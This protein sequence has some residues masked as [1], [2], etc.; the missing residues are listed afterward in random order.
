[1]KPLKKRVHNLEIHVLRA[2]EKSHNPANDLTEDESASIYLY[3]CEWSPWDK[4]FYVVLNRTLRE[5]DR[6]ESTMKPWFKYLKLFLTAL[7]LN[8]HLCRLRMTNIWSI[9]H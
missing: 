2:K 5:S 4:C 3:T 6:S 8:Y 9:G 1:M 7:I